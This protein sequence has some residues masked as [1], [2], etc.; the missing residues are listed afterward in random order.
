MQATSLSKPSLGYYQEVNNPAA[1]AAA[2]AAAIMIVSDEACSVQVGNQC[3]ESHSCAF[4][5]GTPHL[6]PQRSP[7][8]TAPLS[9]LFRPGYT[10]KNMSR[11]LVVRQRM[12]R[13]CKVRVAA[14]PDAPQPTSALYAFNGPTEQLTTVFGSWVGRVMAR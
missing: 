11:T 14:Q 13:R 6:H 10:S 5:T 12:L 4:I 8:Q 1:G 3:N 2:S 9:S 7:Y